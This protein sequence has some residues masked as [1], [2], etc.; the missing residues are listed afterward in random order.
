MSIA[1]RGWRK[2]TGDY[3]CSADRAR[4][5]RQPQRHHGTYLYIQTMASTCSEVVFLLRSHSASTVLTETL[6]LWNLRS[7]RYEWLA[8]FNAKSCSC[9][10][11][12]TGTQLSIVVFA[13]TLTPA[14]LL[15]FGVSALSACGLLTAS[16]S[17]FVN[18][19]IW[20]LSLAH[21]YCLS[22]LIECVY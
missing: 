5:L 1:G 8:S 12:L 15:L 6:N 9:E 18:L 22:V 7:T 16:S 3:P 21:V 13:G 14:L 2:A 4:T 20:L 19:V 11:L 17:V 10:A